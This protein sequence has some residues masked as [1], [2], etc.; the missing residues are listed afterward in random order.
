M[1]RAF[2]NCVYD[3]PNADGGYEGLKLHLTI[4]GK[5]VQKDKETTIFFN[6]GDPVLDFFMYKKWFNQNFSK[7]HLPFVGHSSD[8]GH[9]Y[10][11]SKIFVERH[12]AFDEPLATITPNTEGRLLYWQDAAKEGLE[13][14][15]MI[16]CCAFKW[17]QN[18]Q[19]LKLYVYLTA[20]LMG[21][22]IELMDK[23]PLFGS[24]VKTNA[25][26]K[27]LK[28]NKNSDVLIKKWKDIRNKYK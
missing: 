3:D 22:D 12:I 10:M 18:W 19:E 4:T 17:M 24:T 25:P 27:R 8:V 21:I 11:D 2:L 14:D 5:G 9:F 28:A 15:E 7:F 1:N 23:K 26:K 6:S 13:V 20:N 16:K